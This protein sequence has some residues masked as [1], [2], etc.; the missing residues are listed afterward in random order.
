MLGAVLCVI[1]VVGMLVA[2]W[3]YRKLVEKRMVEHLPCAFLYQRGGS[4]C[5]LLCAVYVYSA[6]AMSASPHQPQ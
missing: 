1:G 6:S 4:Y 2:P 3:L 5:C